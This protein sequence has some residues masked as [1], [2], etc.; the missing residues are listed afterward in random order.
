ML[1]N[2]RNQSLGFRILVPGVGVPVYSSGPKD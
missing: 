1:G 2:L